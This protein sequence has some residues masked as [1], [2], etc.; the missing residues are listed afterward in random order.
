MK[1]IKLLCALLLSAS[2][3]LLAQE[4]RQDISISTLGVWQPQ[5]NGNGA[6]QNSSMT[7]GALVSY[8]YLLTPRSGLEL[9]YSFAQYSNYYKVSFTSPTVHLRQQEITAAYVY[10]RN[11]GNFNPFVEVGVGGYIFTPIRDFG[12]TSLDTKQN[13]NVGALGC[14]G[15][16]YELSPSWDLRLEYRAFFLKAPDFGMTNVRTNRYTVISTPSV[17]FAYH[18]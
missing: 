4:S 8:R 1:K 5:V 12:T 2:G 18:F 3:A 17:G 14:A 11:Y 9:N 7:L 6:R 16:A 10:T 13:T 15:V